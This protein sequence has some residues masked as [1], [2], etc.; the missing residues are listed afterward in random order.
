[1][2]MTVAVGPVRPF[3]AFFIKTS[4]EQRL[5]R[6]HDHASAKKNIAGEPPAPGRRECSIPAQSFRMTPQELQVLVDYHYWARDRLLEAV[7]PLTAEQF[8]RDLGNSFASVRD[9]LS[10]LQGAEWIW[11][12]RF[13]GSSPTSGLPHERF[14]DLGSV[15]AAWA[16]TEAGLRAFVATLD[17]AGAEQ[18][19]EYRLL[20]GQPGASRAWQMVQHVVNHATYHRGQVTTMLRQ[21]GAAPPKSM[22]LI[23]FYRQSE[24]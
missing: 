8:T 18:V 22:D 19:L 12:S 3:G 16:D 20:S 7:E 9:T 13:Q 23:A 11:L 10:H 4:N 17:P 24:R 5:D 6:H 1:M 14:P 2:N 15:Q 21:L